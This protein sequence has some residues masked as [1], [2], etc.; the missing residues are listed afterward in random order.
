MITE[1][2]KKQMVQKTFTFDGKKTVTINDIKFGEKNQRMRTESDVS[3]TYNGK[4]ILKGNPFYDSA[5]Q[6][7]RIENLDFEFDTKN[8]L[9]KTAAWLSEGKI[10]KN[11]NP[12]LQF[13]MKQQFA[14][15]ESNI[16]KFLT[17]NKIAEGI[18]LNGRLLKLI[19]QKQILVIEKNY[20]LFIEL[21]GTSEIEVLKL[22]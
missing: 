22:D 20:V 11:L 16:K 17:K 1:V 8:K 6:N 9:H 14:D 7:I 21:I 12:Y 10:L 3:G 2:A 5:S 4:I 19:P 15:M 18:I 13:P